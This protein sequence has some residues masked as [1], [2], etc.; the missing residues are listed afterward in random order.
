[1]KK[2]L[3]KFFDAAFLRFLLVGVVNTLVGTGVMYGLYNLAHCG[4]WFSSA[5]NYVVGSVVSY[6]LNKYFTF[7]RSGRDA[8]DVL[9]FVLNIAVCY[10]V[11]YGAAQPLARALLAGAS[12]TVRDNVAM[13]FGM[14]LFTGLNYLGQRL[15]VFRADDA[16]QSSEEDA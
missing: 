9:R 7:R 6:F 12:E 4:Y 15:F 16:A 2:L 1:M 14:C 8:K 10:A 11:A 3:A 5:M 13:A